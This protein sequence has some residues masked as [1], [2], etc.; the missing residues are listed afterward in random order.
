MSSHKE[1]RGI[2]IYDPHD[3]AMDHWCMQNQV[4]LVEIGLY[5][6]H[7]AATPGWCHLTTRA[8]GSGSRVFYP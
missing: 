3:G 4:D 2:D 1:G 8:P 5:M 6:E 7:P